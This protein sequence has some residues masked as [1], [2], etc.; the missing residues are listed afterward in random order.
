M[1]SFYDSRSN[2]FNTAL[3]DYLRNQNTIAQ[4]QLE[5]AKQLAAGKEQIQTAQTGIK[6]GGMEA[7]IKDKLQEH[8]NKFAD[9]MGLDFSVQ[10][11]GKPLLQKSSQLLKAKAT[12]MRES[13]KAR[14][15]SRD[16]TEMEDMGE[17]PNPVETDLPTVRETSFMD[18][19]PRDV[20][21]QAKPAPE[22]EADAPVR[23]SAPE[24][25][26]DT[27]EP[28]APASEDAEAPQVEAPEP[29]PRPA[30]RGA[31]VERD[32]TTQAAIDRGEPVEV[33]A[34]SPTSAPVV[35][36][37]ERIPEPTDEDVEVPE[38]PGLA[39]PGE[40]EAPVRPPVGSDLPPA[41][42]T[43]SEGTSYIDESAS[44]ANPFSVFYRGDITDP[45]LAPGRFLQ[46]DAP[47]L[48]GPPRLTQ[49][50]PDVDFQFKAPIDPAQ[51][52]ARGPFT[53]K[54]IDR[55]NA[56]TSDT[57]GDA[58]QPMRD[59]ILQR[60]AAA[61]ARQQAESGERGANEGADDLA[62]E[63]QTGRNL[64]N[65][66]D[67]QPPYLRA[68]VPAEPP[69]AQPPG[70]E[71]LPTGGEMTDAL[72]DT[73]N[74]NVDRVSSQVNDLSSQVES[75]VNDAR[76]A[77]Q[78][79][80]DDLTDQAS[81]MAS[82]LGEKA[83][84]MLGDITGSDVLG[85]LGSLLGIGADLLGPI[86]G[87]VGLFEAAKGIAEDQ[88]DAATDPYAKVR[89]LINQGQ[90][91][92]DGLEANIASDQFAEKIGANA[93]KFGSLAAPVFSTEGM[94]GGSMHF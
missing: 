49:E 20:T 50:L 61:N 47:V 64:G 8:L 67:E 57:G 76:Q 1:A 14:D 24:P 53:K 15:D 52:R 77:V 28:Q 80:I 41:P 58:L 32:P 51:L 29:P 94:G 26:P 60:R 82:D 75:Q 36:Q 25:T 78:G 30:L 74:Q 12:K 84:S 48:R 19:K 72:Q 11:L 10:G 13:G 23:G 31:E 90:A 68:G 46:T 93:P 85:G 66:A 18:A 88:N 38:Q 33:D 3:G 81:K 79:S 89:A 21:G 54:G 86:L 27:V 62:A 56:E 45:A 34:F 9:E 35:R 91:K 43:I 7:A 63:N 2:D 16:G 37:P 55:A 39:G 59:E 87:G 65:I 42:E 22:P 69:T 4:S 92:M 70:P 44:T 40:V 71:D 5:G 83:T 6:A 17:Q 73:V